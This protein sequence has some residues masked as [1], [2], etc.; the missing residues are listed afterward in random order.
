MPGK[1][2][3]SVVLALFFNLSLAS[4]IAIIDSGVDMKHRAIAPFA[5]VNQEEIPDNN[6]DDDKNGY[7][8]DIHGWNFAENNHEVIDYK[9]LGTFSPDTYRF[10]DVQYKAMIGQATEEE[11]AWIREKVKDQDFIRELSTFG[12]FIHGTHVSGIAIRDLQDSKILAIKLLPTEVSLPKY[13]DKNATKD[14]RMTLVKSALKELAA[15]QMNL[16]EEISIYIDGHGAKVANGS[17]GTGYAQAKKISAIVFK[18]IFWRDATEEELHEISIHFLNSLISEGQ[19]M[20]G[21][22]SGTLFVFAAGND[23]TNND[24]YPTSPANLGGTNSI[25]VAA[26]HKRNS[27]ASFSNFGVETVDVAAPGLGINSSI[28]G[29]EYLV[30][31]GTSQA[32]PYVANVASKINEINSGLEPAQVKKIL[33][34]TVDK[35]DFLKGKVK[36]GGI[37][38]SDRALYAAN[39]TRSGTLE[40]A[41]G[42]AIK[43]VTDIPV[44]KGINTIPEFV[45]TL[46]LQSGF[47]F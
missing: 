3:L 40:Q 43:D 21:G 8:D 33:M 9:Y 27:L 31:S 26:T 39:L 29:D 12:N 13:N 25:S 47:A 38:N 32:A 28:P 44:E 16:M 14:F 46:P 36:S 20:L 17:F 19:R 10:F 41:I 24:E 18:G 11:L 22:A 15:Q 6:R 1:I 35:K 2:F 30:V 23:G 5:W 45:F 42:M 37:V 7:E 4:T 34:D